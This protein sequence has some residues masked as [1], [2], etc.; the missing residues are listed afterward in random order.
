MMVLGGGIL[1]P[2]HIWIFTILTKTVKPMVLSLKYFNNISY[3][4][5]Q[6]LD[7]LANVATHAIYWLI[8][9]RKWQ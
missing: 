9:A 1:G 5:K 7:V 4:Y 3:I 2:Y 8:Y 6:Q